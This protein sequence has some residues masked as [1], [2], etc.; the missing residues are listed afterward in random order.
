MMIFMMVG[1]DPT[2]PNSGGD[3]WLFY[4]WKVTFL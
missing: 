2:A 3:R 4:G 1:S